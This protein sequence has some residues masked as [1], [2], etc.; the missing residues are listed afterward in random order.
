[1]Q[2]LGVAGT[3]GACHVSIVLWHAR[4]VEIGNETIESG[5]EGSDRLVCFG[6]N[7]NRCIL[8][9]CLIVYFNIGFSFLK[10]GSFLLHHHA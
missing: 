7:D 3:D 10:A 6:C 8:S 9:A 5:Q 2:Q 4:D 1:M